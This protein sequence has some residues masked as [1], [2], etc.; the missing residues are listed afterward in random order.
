MRKV[1]LS[2][3]DNPYNPFTQFDDWLSFD[4]NAG[5]YS[6][7]VLARFSHYSNTLSDE[8]NEYF[9]ENAIDNVITF[10]P[11]GTDADFIKVEF[12]QEVEYL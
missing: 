12:E 11:T 6:A 7:N 9:T 10:V 5:Y 4:T 8:E 3:S 2:T 1:A